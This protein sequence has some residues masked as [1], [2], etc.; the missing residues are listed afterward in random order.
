MN[1]DFV[2]DFSPEDGRMDRIIKALQEGGVYMGRY[3]D[4]KR[5][6]C[7]EYN[8]ESCTFFVY[9][10]KMKIRVYGKLP[11]TILYSSSQ[12]EEKAKTKLTEIK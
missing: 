10:K 3:M 12:L 5:D 1:K 9:P 4:K 7:E 11:V 6:Y 2:K 8:W